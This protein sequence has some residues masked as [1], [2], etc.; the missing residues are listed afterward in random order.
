MAYSTLK[1]KGRVCCGT[2]T[3]PSILSPLLAHASW[4]HSSWNLR[5]EGV[6]DAPPNYRANGGSPNRQT[7]VNTSLTSNHRPTPVKTLTHRGNGF[8][9]FS[10]KHVLF[11]LLGREETGR[12][13]LHHFCR[14]I[15][16]GTLPTAASAVPPQGSAAPQGPAM[17]QWGTGLCPRRVPTGSFFHCPFT[18]WLSL[19]TKLKPF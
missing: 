12:R 18:S 7:W 14:S 3:S 17:G 19:I 6:V 1:V 10:E 4:F 8:K 2:H 5:K 15:L 11:L 9:P 16:C 13:A